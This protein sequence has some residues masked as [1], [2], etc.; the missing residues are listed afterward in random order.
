MQ[1]FTLKEW[2]LMYDAC[3][4]PTQYKIANGDFLVTR[5]ENTQFEWCARRFGGLT[6]YGHRFTYVVAIPG[7]GADG[8]ELLV[9]DDLMKW[10]KKTG[11]ELVEAKR[12]ENA[13][14]QQE[15]F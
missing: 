5:I 14:V 6:C 9:R 11:R 3:P 12:R 10:V 7:G 4:I 2:Q 1:Q 13:P 8:G 15:L